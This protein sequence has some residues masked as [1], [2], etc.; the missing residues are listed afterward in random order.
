[1]SCQGLPDLVTTPEI[2]NQERTTMEATTKRHIVDPDRAS[3]H[4]TLAAKCGCT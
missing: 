1:M 2:D 4:T 3:H